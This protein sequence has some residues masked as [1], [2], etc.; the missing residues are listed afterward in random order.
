MDWEKKLIKA[1][2]LIIS[3]I[4]ISIKLKLTKDEFNN[5]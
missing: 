3:A 1:A 5:R 2:K 4:K